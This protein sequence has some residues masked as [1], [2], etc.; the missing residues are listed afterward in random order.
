MNIDKFCEYAKSSIDERGIFPAPGFLNKT[1]GKCDILA[2]M[3]HPD[4]IVD[5]AWNNWM[6]QEVIEQ[7][8]SLDFHTKPEHGTELDSVLIIFHFRRNEP[9]PCRLGIMEYS[10]NKGQP[11]TRP[12]NWE[13]AFWKGVFSEVLNYF[14][15]LPS[16]PIVMSKEFQ[17]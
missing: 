14:N 1:G 5:L 8:I 4:D 16:I 3:A 15:T 2:L 17:A 7:I 10:W 13:N 9:A 6:N 12:V 11:V